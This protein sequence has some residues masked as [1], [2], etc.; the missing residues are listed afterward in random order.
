MASLCICN[1]HRHSALFEPAIIAWQILIG[2][3][4]NCLKSR[5][6]CKVYGVSKI[7]LQGLLNS[8][9]LKDV[10]SAN[11]ALLSKKSIVR[12]NHIASHKYV[13]H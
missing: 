6:K 3:L 10:F 2:Q 5:R 13:R 8:Y 11:A 9:E 4:L 12:I 7:N 1:Y